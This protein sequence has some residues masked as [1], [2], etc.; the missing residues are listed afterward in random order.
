MR[1]KPNTVFSSTH[2]QI[3]INR[4]HTLPGSRL[5]SSWK[6]RSCRQ[7]R[8]AGAHTRSE[9]HTHLHGGPLQRHSTTC[10]ALSENAN[11][12]FTEE[13]LSVQKGLQTNS[14]TNG[15]RAS[16]F[17]TARGSPLAELSE[18]LFNCSSWINDT[19]LEIWLRPQEGK[20]QSV[21]PRWL[22]KHSRARMYI[23]ACSQAA[24]A[25]PDGGQKWAVA[26]LVFHKSDQETAQRQHLN[27]LSWLTV[28]NGP[29]TIKQQPVKADL[30]HV[31]WGAVGYGVG[32]LSG[33]LLLVLVSEMEVSFSMWIQ[34]EIF[35]VFWLLPRP[36]PLFFGVNISKVPN[37]VTSQSP[38]S[39]W[40]VPHSL[41]ERR[42]RGKKIKKTRKEGYQQPVS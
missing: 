21:R 8:V 6:M 20:S 35:K 29:I 9:T 1:M 5:A 11:V 38:H 42:E 32:Y 16:I 12:H 15:G 3:N 34:N 36:H 33:R 18:Q 22:K 10:T 39:Q 28:T 23:H 17:T 41:R 27:N 37:M 4:K 25:V 24:Q 2:T 40:H 7:Q 31:F 30:L 14:Q 26:Q 13:C 19:A